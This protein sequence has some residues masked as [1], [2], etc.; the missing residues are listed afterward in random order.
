MLKR[1]LNQGLIVLI[2][3]LCPIGILAGSGAS[4]ET[5]D[6]PSSGWGNGVLEGEDEA[7]LAGNENIAEEMKKYISPP[8]VLGMMDRVQGQ[9]QEEE[10][11]R[12]IFYSWEEIDQYKREFEQIPEK[13][14]NSWRDYFDLLSVGADEEMKDTI[15]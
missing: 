12:T 9:P 8:E 14:S 11:V 7:E 3:V 15:K 13:M 1:H 4:S 10:L 5:N 2:L 6:N